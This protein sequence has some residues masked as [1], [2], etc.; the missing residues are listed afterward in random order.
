MSF[1]WAMPW[2]FLALPWPLF[3]W[4]FCKRVSRPLLFAL[5]VPFF[6]TVSRAMDGQKNVTI[7]TRSMLFLFTSWC[8]LVIA[9]AGP[10][11]VGPPRVLSH[12]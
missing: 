1:E 6:A 12:Y 9:L 7:K 3:V 8:F 10:R 2:A 4:F 5:Y 11:F